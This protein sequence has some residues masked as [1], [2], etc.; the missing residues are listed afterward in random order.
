MPELFSYRKPDVGA[1]VSNYTTS[2][3]F[4]G[5]TVSQ[6]F[7]VIYGCGAFMDKVLLLPKPNHRLELN[8]GFLVT[9]RHSD[10]VQLIYS[11]TTLPERLV[12]QRVE[13]ISQYTGII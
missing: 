2:H 13:K 5:N 11:L 12:L 1:L 9:V 8:S 4:K 7:I 3:I 10:F 6:K